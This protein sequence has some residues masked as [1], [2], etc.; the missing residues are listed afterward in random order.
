MALSKS[1]QRGA[2]TREQLAKFEIKVVEGIAEGDNTGSGSF[3]AVYPVTVEGVSRIAKRLHNILLAPDIR[4]QEKAGIRE[5]FCEECLL[6]SKLDHPCIVQFVGVHFHGSDVTLV[7]ERL[8]TDL[9]RFLDPEQHP[10]IPLSIKL[11]V[12]LNVSS[13]LLYLHT[14]IQ[15]PVIHRDLKP[16]N[17]L[18]TKDL[19]AKIADLGVSKLLKNYPRNAAVHTKCPGTL[20]YMPPEALSENPRY[21]ASLDIFSYGQLALYV[22]IQMFPHPYNVVRNPRMTSAIR[23]GE[24]EVLRRQKWINQLSQDHCL[25]SIIRHCLND[26]PEARPTTLELNNKIKTLCVQNPRSLADIISVWDNSE[27]S[28]YDSVVGN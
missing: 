9:D 21:D 27:V 18:L 3:G 7:M 14:Q 1:S 4:P 13:G 25:H 8:H 22:A 28:Y 16:E 6:L 26:E 17:I 10:N 24:S 23:N 19:H 12:L 11:S 5:K 15:E 2:S 20:A